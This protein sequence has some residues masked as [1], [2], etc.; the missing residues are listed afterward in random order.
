MK[1]KNKIKM[2]R[3]WIERKLDEDPDTSW[4]GKFTDEISDYAIV[5]Q[6]EHAGK[7]CKDLGDE[8]ELP[9]K[10]RDTGF[11]CLR[12]MCRTSRKIGSMLTVWRCPRPYM[13]TVALKRRTKR[14]PDGIGN[15][16]RDWLTTLGVSL[17]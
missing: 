6:G 17:A 16:W 12:S 8:D 1:T 4:L 11:S 2:G 10:G 3:V 13:N 7:F 5:K 9:G 14:M 15:G